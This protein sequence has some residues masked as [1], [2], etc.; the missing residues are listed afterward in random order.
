VFLSPYFLFYQIE[1]TR[2]P[3]LE[4]YDELTAFTED[5]LNTYFRNLFSP[6]PEITYVTSMT[7]MTD[8]E[9][10]LGEPIRVDYNTTISFTASSTLIPDVT[11]LDVLLAN[12]FEGPNAE[13]YALAVAAGLDPE[14]IFVTTSA[15]TFGDD[16]EV[17]PEIVSERSKAGKAA[18]GMAAF[19]FAFVTMIAGFALYRRKKKYVKVIETN[20][21]ED[22]ETYVGDDRTLDSR[23]HT[24]SMYHVDGG[25]SLDSSTLEWGEYPKE[26]LPATYSSILFTVYQSDEEDSYET[27]SDEEEEEEIVWPDRVDEDSL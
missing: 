20:T 3:I 15:V 5:Y 7:G 25:A 13:S 22:G 19:A 2:I 6:A 8:S 18:A 27:G 14:N 17:T 16:V 23:L 26:T 21:D 12:A 9:F 1:Q 10:R 24:P 4:D 11:D